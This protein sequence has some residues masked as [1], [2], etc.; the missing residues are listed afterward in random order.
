MLTD[1]SQE[2]IE[3][4]QRDGF[5][6]IPNFLTDG[7]LNTWRSVTDE[8]VEQ[9]LEAAAKSDGLDRTAWTNQADP[10]NF[11]AQVFV[12]C[13]RLADTHAGMA[14]LMLDP[15]LGRMAGSLAGVDGIRIWH[16]QALYKQPWGNP[17]GWHLD[18]P[19]WSFTSPDSLSIWVAL[20]DATLANGCLW[21]LP[22]T[23]KQFTGKNAGISTNQRSLFDSYPEWEKLDAVPA[24]CAAG[25]AVFH[26]GR[27]AHGAGANMTP[28]PRRAM[29]CAYMP[30]GSTFNGTQ[31]VLPP[32]YFAALKP[33][34]V[35][36]NDRQN[37]LIWHR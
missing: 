2:Q 18:N 29:T 36:N 37:P 27:T 25:S 33:G 32:D 7:E 3:R 8:A 9:R 4:Y 15:R 11:Y 31:N 35:L 1:V 12:Q 23:H 24:D 20:D 19:Y 21:Y 5:L 14:D 17:T 26:N 22:G 6:I 30:D 10:N 13:V 28:R 34:D 16:D